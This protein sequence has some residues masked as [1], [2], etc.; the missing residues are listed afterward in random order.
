M[1]TL[2]YNWYVPG[3]NYNPNP[4]VGDVLA[5]QHAVWVVAQVERDAPHPA[6]G[7]HLVLWRV[8]PGQA[9]PTD[10]PVPDDERVYQ[11]NGFGW[12]V[13]RDPDHLPLCGRCLEPAPCR[14]SMA[15]KIAASAVKAMSRWER[16]GVCPACGEVITQRQASRTWLDNLEIPGGPP[17]TFHVGRRRCR[18]QADRYE[19]RVTR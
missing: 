11:L 7:G 8:H 2:P 16:T 17:V 3:T 18:W 9:P 10:R 19:E 14:A 5:H 6:P 4:R 1:T 15:A 12:Q 13:Y